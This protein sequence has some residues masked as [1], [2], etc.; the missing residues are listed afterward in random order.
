MLKPPGESVWVF[1]VLRERRLEGEPLRLLLASVG[2]ITTGLSGQFFLLISG[3]LVARI[4]GIE[5]RGYLAGLS[6][7]PTL[8]TSLGNLGIPAACTYYLSRQPAQTCQILGET[9]RIMLVQVT[10]LLALLMV[11][12]FFWC[13]D[14]PAEVQIAMYPTLVM[15]PAGL[16]YQYALAVLQGQ[17]RFRALNRLRLLPAALY[18]FS[19]MLLFV[20]G[21]H[22]LLPVMTAWVSAY[23]LTAIVAIVIALKH[24]RFDSRGAPDLRRQFITFGLRGH[25]GAVSVV[26][27]L[28]IDQA[29]VALFL[30]PAALGLYVV[31]CSFTNLPRLISQSAGLM[32]YPAVAVRQGTDSAR[33]LI[34]RFFW[35]V[36]LLN[37]ACSAVLIVMMPTL[38]P[39]F[40][41]PEFSPAVSIARILLVGTT[42]VA[43]RRILAEGLRGLGNPGASTIAE[44]SMYPWLVIGG[45]LLMLRYEAEGVAVALAVGYGLSLAVAVTA[46]LRCVPISGL[47]SVPLDGALK[48]DPR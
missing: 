44:V 46:S 34:W 13:R 33:C 35:G 27:S 9:Y 11:I 5:G 12:L 48:A 39:L 7:W 42:L 41:G 16:G 3:L 32:A 38:L 10:V 28:P 47:P 30:P 24:V 26:D 31:A 36:T 37:L 8:L 43:S 22:R 20:L 45:P 29:A 40:F 21:E 17:Q 2:T 14:K 23:V 6:I 15:I 19:V 25:L 18:A 4:L 1:N